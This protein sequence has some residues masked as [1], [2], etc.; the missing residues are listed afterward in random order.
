MG[1]GASRGIWVFSEETGLSLE[2]LGKGRELADKLRTELAAI[3]IGHHLESRIGELVNHGADRVFVADDPRLKVFQVEPF[4]DIIIDLVSDHKPDALLVG[5]TRRGKELAPRVATR[6]GVGCVS[7]CFGLDIGKSGRLLM[8]RLI[9]GG[10]AIATEICNTK[11]QIATISPGAFERAERKS[12]DGRVVRLEVKVRDGRTKILETREKK[13]EGVKIEDAAVVVCGGRGVGRRED[14]KMLEE[15]AKVLG[16]E[17]ACSRPVAVDLKWFT[18]WVG[19]SGHKIKPALY[20]GCGIS[21][22][23]QHI[24]GIRDSRTIVAINTNSDAPIFH[25]ADYGIVGDFREVV[26]ALTEALRKLLEK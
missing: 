15:L 14:F 5:A 22:A 18:D 1:V 8:D 26:P 10:S 12:R 7:D 23:I 6:L 2:M 17:V 24:A 21:G 25:S 3:L 9:Y 19:L 13:H 11:P 16:G 4:T 20:V